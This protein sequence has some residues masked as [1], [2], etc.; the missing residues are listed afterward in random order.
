MALYTK[1]NSAEI[2]TI[3]SQYNLGSLGYFSLFE[4][5]AVNTNFKV[6]TDKGIYVMKVIEERSA[7]ELAFQLEVIEYLRGCG[8]SVPSLVKNVAGHDYVFFSGKPVVIFTYIEGSHVDHPSNRLWR[9]VSDVVIRL[10]TCLDTFVPKHAPW[11]KYAD[12]FSLEESWEDVIGCTEEVR[13]FAGVFEEVKA[14]DCKELRSRVVHGDLSETNILARRDAVSGVIDFDETR[15]DY[16]VYDMAIFIAQ[17]C[18]MGNRFARGHLMYF[19]QEAEKSGQLNAVE[20]SVLPVF[21]RRRLLS[22]VIFFEYLLRIGRGDPIQNRI[23]K[24][25]F[26]ERY[27]QIFAEM[28]VRDWKF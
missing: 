22:S 25:S 11:K 6:T 8:I 20:L 3:I 16:V 27:Q 17:T 19:L 13:E 5:G 18:F 10:N 12:D 28:P 26:K 2:K 24:E 9:D 15:L 7:E 1:L 4:R 21:V 14:V 23:R